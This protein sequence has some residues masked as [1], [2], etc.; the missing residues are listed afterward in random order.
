M[1]LEGFENKEDVIQEFCVPQDQQ[2]FD[3][4]ICWYDVGN[5]EGSAFVLF[6]QDGKLYEVYGS[7]CSCYGLEDQ[8]SPEETS[9]EALQHRMEKGTLGWY[10]NGRYAEKLK[11]VLDDWQ[12]C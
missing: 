1:Y 9:L 12:K 6:E 2:D 5:W 4:L 8:W 7:H 3:V 10:F 11:E